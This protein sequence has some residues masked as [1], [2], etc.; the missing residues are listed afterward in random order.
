MA[1]ALNWRL[2]V[3]RRSKDLPGLPPG[4]EAHTIIRAANLQP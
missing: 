3:V 1:E 2:H 4:G